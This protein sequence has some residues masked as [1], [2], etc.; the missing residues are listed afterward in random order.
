MNDLI[1][2][3]LKYDLIV[4]IEGEKD[5]FEGEQCTVVGT[6][7]VEVAMEKVRKILVGRETKQEL[8]GE[9]DGETLEYKITG[10]RFG[11]SKIIVDLTDFEE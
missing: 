9:M 8:T 1:V 2:W 3:Q 5:I 7:D 11:E 6:D 10:I 4:L